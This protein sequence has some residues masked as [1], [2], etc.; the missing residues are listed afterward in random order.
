MEAHAWGLKLRP[1]PMKQKTWFE[2]QSAGEGRRRAVACGRN[3][4]LFEHPED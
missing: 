3:E 2:Q 1:G 4:N